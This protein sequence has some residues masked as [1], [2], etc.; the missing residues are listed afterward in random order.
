M[1][2]VLLDLFRHNTWA[3][4][5]LIDFCESLDPELI[6]ERMPGT[7]G[8]VYSTLYHMVTSE[9]GYCFRVSGGPLWE[10]LAEPT[11]FDNLPQLSEFADR[12]RKLGAQWEKV[13]Q[14]PDLPTRAMRTS[15]GFDITGR[16]PMAQSIHHADDHRGQ[17]L[18]VLGARGIEV[19]ELDIWAFAFEFNLMREAATT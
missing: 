5:K 10:P 16:V 14:D 12:F 7:F 17:I 15:D 13:A 8:S 4:L 11:D 19:P 1:S 9:E 6:R 2:V 18:S 3:T